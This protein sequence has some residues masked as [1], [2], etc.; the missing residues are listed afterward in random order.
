[1]ATASG[2]VLPMT[3][4]NSS[5]I[6]ERHRV[7]GSPVLDPDLAVIHPDDLVARLLDDAVPRHAAPRIDASVL[8][9][10]A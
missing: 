6:R 4:V 7:K 8:T 9:Y 10:L 2:F 1:M 3:S 5:K